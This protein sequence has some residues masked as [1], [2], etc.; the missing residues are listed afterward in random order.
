MEEIF[1]GGFLIKKKKNSSPPL[2]SCCGPS[3]PVNCRGYHVAGSLSSSPRW[4]LS[5][6]L[7]PTRRASPS[8]LSSIASPTHPL[9]RTPV[10][11]RA[12]VTR[13]CEG[14]C[15]HCSFKNAVLRNL[16][17]SSDCRPAVAAAA[18]AAAALAA[19]GGGRRK[20][21][22]LAGQPVG[23]LG[24]GSSRPPAKFKAPPGPYF[25]VASLPAAWGR[26]PHRLTTPSA[27]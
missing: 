22:P 16:S 26:G 6:W 20:G 11:E 1:G 4:S 5:L 14:E 21:H 17:P 12:S 15:G 18:A 10:S 7:P 25:G 3:N 27:S 13:G 19:G 8:P 24:L 23:S 2:R 9:P